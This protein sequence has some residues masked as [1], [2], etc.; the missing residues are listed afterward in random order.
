[1]SHQSIFADYL[2]PLAINNDEIEGT[3]YVAMET[4]TYIPTVAIMTGT[5]PD[6]FMQASLDVEATHKQVPTFVINICQHFDKILGCEFE[7]QESMACN[8][9]A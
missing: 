9:Y 6:F 8:L 3:L 2:S 7:I 4:G 1:M 5:K